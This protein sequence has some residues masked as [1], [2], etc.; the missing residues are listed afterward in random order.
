VSTTLTPVR[1]HVYADPDGAEWRR[2][3]GEVQSREP[4]PDQPDGMDAGFWG[5]ADMTT[6]EWRA[7]I[8][9]HYPQSVAA[10][11]AALADPMTAEWAEEDDTRIQQDRERTHVVHP[12]DLI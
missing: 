1:P 12:H 5:N 7:W 4:N 2:A 3:E 9:S 8:A 10:F 6:D 11:D